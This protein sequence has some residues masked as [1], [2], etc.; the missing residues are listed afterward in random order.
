MSSDACLD[1][2]ALK[3]KEWRP[4]DMSLAMQQSTKLIVDRTHLVLAS[5]KL[6]LQKVLNLDKRKQLSS[7][8]VKIS[9]CT[10]YQLHLLL[11]Q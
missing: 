1:Q 4:K 9:I 8:A 6:V 3:V 2:K 5:G 11:V 7:F 10:Y